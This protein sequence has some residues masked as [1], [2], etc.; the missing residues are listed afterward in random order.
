MTTANL[1]P[2]APNFLQYLQDN[3]VGR[4]TSR[5]SQHP[6]LAARTTLDVHYNG[7]RIGKYALYG[8]I[9]DLP[10]VKRTYVGRVP[11]CVQPA[12]Y[13]NPQIKRKRADRYKGYF[14]WSENQKY[15]FFSIPQF[16]IGWED[17]NRI[18]CI[19]DFITDTVYR[20]NNCL[21][22]GLYCDSPAVAVGEFGKDKYFEFPGWRLFDSRHRPITAKRLTEMDR[23]NRKSFVG[24]AEETEDYSVEWHT[25]S[26]TLPLSVNKKREQT[27]RDIVELQFKN[28]E[29]TWQ[30]T[31]KHHISFP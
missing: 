21:S 5:Q 17:T 30:R 15:Y 16:Q 22:L 31:D 25:S 27:P 10:D 7:G 4:I 29:G 3:L 24:Y 9:E 19:F 1:L 20:G 13:D 26:S 28:E 14:H 6:I 11:G 12:F 18:R 2:G 23:S 8:S